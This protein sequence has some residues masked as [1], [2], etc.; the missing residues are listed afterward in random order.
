MNADLTP[1]VVAAGGGSLLMTGIWTYERRRD[2]AMR[3]SRVRLS[4]RFP[5]GVEP[6]SAVAALDSLSG[7]PWSAEVVFELSATE[8]GIEHAIWVPEAVRSPVESALTGAIPGL[9]LAEAVPDHSTAVTVSRQLSVST[10]VILSTDDPAAV[11]RVFLTGLSALHPGERVV[12]RWALRPSH[13]PTL[14]ESDKPSARQREVERAWRRKAAS[15]GVQVSGAMLIAASPGRAS[16][17]TNQ[18][19]SVLRSRRGLAGGIRTTGRRDRFALAT[20]PR[21]SRRSG[22]LS[23]NELLPLLMVPLGSEVVPGVSVGVSRQLPVPRQVPSKGR[24]LFL[25]HD[26][27]GERPVA[28]SAES[29]KHHLAVLGR[30]GSGKSA[31]IG[32]AFFSD[33]TAGYGGVLIDPKGDLVTDILDRIPAQHADRVV[34]LDPAASGP[35]PGLDLF[36]LGDPELRSDVILSILRNLSD[37]WGP[38]IQ[39][40]LALGLR[41]VA[42]LPNP[43]L[44]DWLRLYS[45]P[46]LR[47][48]AAARLD[49]IRQAEWAAYEALSAAAQQEFTAPATSRIAGLLSRPALRAV[50]NQTA[51]KLDIGRLLTERKWL[52]VSLAPGTL[53]EPAAR[54]LGAI[55]TYLT[56][57]AVEARVAVPAEQRHPVFLYFDELQSLT[58]LPIGLELFFERTRGLGCGVVVA[59]QALA[60]LPETIRVSLLGNVGSL[61][62]FAAGADEATRIAKEL[63]GLSVQDVQSLGRFEVAARIH[64]QAGAVTLTGR[65]EPLPPPAGHAQAI[66]RA[67]ALRYGT[68]PAEVEANLARRID[69]PQA[70]QNSGVGRVGRQP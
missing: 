19:E 18:V 57:T 8:H 15:A 44:S 61:V 10:P 50:L 43:V 35:M 42:E 22:W 24:V 53:G 21:T 68:D 29:S 25:G 37:S 62:T 38:R 48:R 63:P 31:T 58:S 4:V 59:T 7:L 23:S 64:T 51:P 14:T 70:P 6:A 16:N 17:L 3:A 45:E 1:A 67:S 56:W 47:R 40:Y 41:S 66:R 46:A 33:L 30:T 9:R 26:S 52:L 34:V 12:V 2:R 5:A 27:R 36:G 13:A 28:L 69:G 39:Q 49:P 55:V 60:R 11:S 54:L 20:M 65:T 32:N